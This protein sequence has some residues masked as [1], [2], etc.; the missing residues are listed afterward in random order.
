MRR[1][2][3]VT[4]EESEENIMSEEGEQYSKQWGDYG[5]HYLSE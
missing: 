4:G 3:A 1:E 5:N 2:R